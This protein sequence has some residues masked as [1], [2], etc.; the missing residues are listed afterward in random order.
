MKLLK[1]TF[2][3][4]L[5]SCWMKNY[6]HGEY[7]ILFSKFDLILIFNLF[8]LKLLNLFVYKKQGY[9]QKIKNKIYFGDNLLNYIK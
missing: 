9:Y 3:M 5:L 6:K 1:E 4:S 7:S 8:I 2:Q